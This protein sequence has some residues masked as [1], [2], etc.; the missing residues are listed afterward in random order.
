MPVISVNIKKGCDGEIVVRAGFYAL[1]MAGA[2]W[3][4]AVRTAQK[5]GWWLVEAL[6]PSADPRHCMHIDADSTEHHYL[7][8]ASALTR[9]W[10]V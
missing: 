1:P 4:R 5:R 10:Y 3:D 6:D 8:P 9:D 7:L 2:L